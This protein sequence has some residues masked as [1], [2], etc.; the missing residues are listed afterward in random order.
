MIEKSID[1]KY[2]SACQAAGCQAAGDRCDWECSRTD[3]GGCTTLWR[4]K[5]CWTGHFKWVNY[6]FIN[7]VLIKLLYY[8]NAN[9]QGDQS[10]VVI[11]EIPATWELWREAQSIETSHWRELVLSSRWM[12]SFCT[13]LP[14]RRKPA[15]AALHTGMFLE[16]RT[17][18]LWGQAG[19]IQKSRTCFL[20]CDVAKV[21]WSLLD[22]LLC[23]IR[24]ALELL[25][26][27]R[28]LKYDS[29]YTKFWE[30][31][32]VFWKVY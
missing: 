16:A 7:S 6:V 25:G 8:K 26:T 19:C 9:K 20:L 22:F 32:L 24:I 15:D 13:A 17:H 2:V 10:D 29:D 27:F 31:F 11:H 28:D 14:R 18:V 23:K 30:Q 5:N 12:L 4:Y 1:R 21:L 3:G